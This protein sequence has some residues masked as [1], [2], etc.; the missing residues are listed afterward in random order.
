MRV[1]L[2]VIALAL[3]VSCNS[4]GPAG[5]AGPAGAPGAAGPMGPPGSTGMTGMTGMTGPAGAA[6]L[7][8]TATEAAGANCPNGGTAI[9][10]GADTNGD[11]MLAD[12]EVTSRTYVCGAAPQTLVRVEPELAGL[13]CPLGGVAVLTGRDA[14]G[15]G[16]LADAEV[17]NRRYVCGQSVGDIV[18]EGDV[19][20]RN[21]VDAQVYRLVRRITGRLVIGQDDDSCC[22]DVMAPTTLEFPNLESVGELHTTNTRGLRSLR[23][24]RLTTLAFEGIDDGE[25]GRTGSSYVE[26]MNDLET[27]DVPL[28]RTFRH[29]VSIRFNPQLRDCALRSLRGALLDLGETVRVE[30][31]DNGRSIDGGVGCSLASA[32]WVAR[33]TSAFP[34]GADGGPVVPS[35][36]P[37]AGQGK[38]FAFCDPAG[39]SLGAIDT[40]CAQAFDGG[41][42]A[43]LDSAPL[44][45]AFRA[46]ANQFTGA[47]VGISGQDEWPDGGGNP[48]GGWA[49]GTGVPFGFTNW[50]P[51]EP[52][53]SGG[54]D[55]VEVTTSGLWNDNR[56]STQSVFACE[57]P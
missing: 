23:F 39:T 11:G 44:N 43:I 25:G 17:M 41:R 28:L 55:C 40:T 42:G 49:W 53:D 27:L 56:C 32:C 20:I 16:M 24:P 48:D 37:D 10:V 5:P 19:W 7:V 45:A 13:N 12:S 26:S 50:A 35:F 47:S 52:N 4:A 30:V 2:T 15:D 3:V 6:T 38:T 36:F 21:S 29:D 31:Q 33:P 14:N 46:R 9:L 57:L 1:L 51:G 22:S 34:R 8:R 18:V 54:E